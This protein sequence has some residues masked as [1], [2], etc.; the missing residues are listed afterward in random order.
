MK[1]K[2]E[3]ININ[4]EFEKILPSTPRKS[5]F[6]DSEDYE[7]LRKYIINHPYN[8]LCKSNLP[9]AEVELIEY[10]DFQRNNGIDKATEEHKHLFF[11][12]QSE[13]GKEEYCN[14]VGYY[15]KYSKTFVLMP[16]S[17]IVAQAYGHVPFPSHR[18]GNKYMDG[19][20]MY[21]THPIT[22]NTPEEAATFVLGQKADLDEW[23]DRRGKGVLDYY[24]NLV[25]M[26]DSPISDIIEP[27]SVITAVPVS[28]KH[29]FMIFAKGI[30][31]ASGYFDSEKGHFYIL[32][33]SLLALNAECEYEKSASGMARKRIIATACTCTG[34]FYKVNKD[35]KC[36]SAS[37]AACCVLG[38]NS[39][40]IEWKDA[41]GKGLHD[42]F[43]ERFYRKKNSTQ[44]MNIF[45]ED[46]EITNDNVIHIFYL[47]KNGEPERE[48]KAFGYFDE[49]TKTFILK[50]GS[51]WASEVTKGY[52]QTASEFLRRNHIK[53]NCKVIAGSVIQTRDIICESPSA[54]ASF[55]LGR[56]ANGWIEWTDR[57]GRNLKNFYCQ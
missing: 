55:V 56:T 27:Q 29:I 48:C 54:A 9:F 16:Y 49:K 45:P 4:E 35:T 47:Q 39:S 8:S 22:F 51:K 24:P 57:D 20:N 53:K 23:V 19:K 12:R 21:I 36:R 42:F 44:P 31:K 43:P 10:I 50:G 32:K 14:A 41:D 6:D 2:L 33:D 11:I 26:S 15:Q 37:A 1:T 46:D 40:Y 3:D 25:E 13:K 30:C 28:E 52:Q 17:Y 34:G 7:S 38:K 18:I 5:L